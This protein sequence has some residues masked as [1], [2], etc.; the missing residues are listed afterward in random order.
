MCIRKGCVVTVDIV[1]LH[2]ECVY[3][4]AIL[5]HL[6]Q[7]V[8]SEATVVLLVCDDEEMLR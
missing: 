8:I 3:S 2:G 7:E 1:I 6:L 5:Y 4:I